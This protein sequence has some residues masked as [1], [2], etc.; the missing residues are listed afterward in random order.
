[1]DEVPQPVQ[2]LERISRDLTVRFLELR[3][4]AQQAQRLDAITKRLCLIAAYASV[5]CVECLVGAIKEGLKMGIELE[6]MLE[7]ASI[8]VRVSGARGVVTLCKALSIIEGEM[9]YRS[10]A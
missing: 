6:K 3:R 1:M 4:A 5:G 2:Q 10:S 7:A 9:K 8:A